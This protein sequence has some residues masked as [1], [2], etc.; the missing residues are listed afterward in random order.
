MAIESRFVRPIHAQTDSRHLDSL[1]ADLAARQHGVVARWQLLPI[2]FTRDAIAHRLE[3]GRL[4][5]IHRGVYAVGHSA[6]S[7]D[8]RLMAAVL[9]GGEG[10]V[11]SHRDACAAYGIMQSNRRWIEGTVPA[12][13]K[14]RPGIQ[15]H[16]AR[17]PAD[18][19]TTLRGIPITTVPRAIFD[20]AAVEPRRK[21][22]R[23]I[24][25]ADVR[26]LWDPLSLSDL[27]ERHPHS[28][29]VATVRAI[30]TDLMQ[31]VAISKQDI[32]D[33]LFALLEAARLPLPLTNQYISV[34]DI[35][36]EADCVWPDAKLMAELDGHAVHAT[37]R[38]YES[39][40]VRDR[41][42]AVEGWLVIR[43]TWRQ[44]QDEPD[45]L[46]A[47]LRYLLERRRG[48]AAT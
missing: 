31:G 18:E 3:C 23:A 21:V 48:M 4:H 34:G 32:Q 14:A 35:T 8:G 10:A 28:R 25:E 1:L 43:I 5:V 2:G 19:L 30:L 12:G 9:A 45:E 6:L 46:V 22:E 40:R 37:R 26:R 29:G 7:L 36:Y 44:L 20:L 47:D 39:D 13:A 11:L 27:V 15:F 17:L 24:H 41:R 33:L 42:L 38:N 16:R